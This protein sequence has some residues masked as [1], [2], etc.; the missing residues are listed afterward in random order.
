MI[1][2][3]IAPILWRKIVIVS[4]VVL[5]GMTGCAKSE[6]TPLDEPVANDR[7]PRVEVV[8]VFEPPGE[9]NVRSSFGL[10][11]GV[12]LVGTEETGDVFKTNDSGATWRQVWDGGEAWVFRMCAITSGLRM[13]TFISRRPSRLWSRVPRMKGKVGMCWLAPNPVAPWGWLS[14]TAAR[15]WWD[16]AVLKMTAPAS[17]DHRMRGHRTN[18]LK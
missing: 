6:S 11:D 18:G 14:W 9:S 17:Y 5:A 12:G 4:G 3:S 1:S 16:C 10:A 2:N 7:F 13:D 8:S 15:C